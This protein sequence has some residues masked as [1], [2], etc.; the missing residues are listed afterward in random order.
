MEGLTQVTITIIANNIF[1]IFKREMS[2]N[3]YMNNLLR[4]KIMLEECFSY[5]NIKS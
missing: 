4:P 5:F 3:R 1:K 2:L